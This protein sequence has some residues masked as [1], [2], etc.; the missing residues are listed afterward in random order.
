MNACRS[1]RFIHY[2][3]RAP[4]ALIHFAAHKWKSYCRSFAFSPPLKRSTYFYFQLHYGAIFQRCW[5][6]SIPIRRAHNG[7]IYPDRNFAIYVSA[8]LEYSE[9]PLGYIPCE[10]ARRHRGTGADRARTAKHAQSYPVHLSAD[11]SSNNMYARCLTTICHTIGSVYLTPDRMQ[12]LVLVRPDTTAD[13]DLA[14]FTIVNTL[15]WQLPAI[16]AHHDFGTKILLPPAHSDLEDFIRS[17][18]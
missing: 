12:T 3:R 8:G 5:C 14:A 11:N 4:Y 1:I 16:S 17:L 10:P 15:R 18:V 13:A 7:G 2:S 9:P 6:P